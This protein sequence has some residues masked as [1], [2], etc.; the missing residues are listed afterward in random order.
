[1]FVLVVQLRGKGM[2]VQFFFYHSDTGMIKR[3]VQHS[4]KS[5]IVQIV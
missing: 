3:V 2:V 5:M 1:M 4:D